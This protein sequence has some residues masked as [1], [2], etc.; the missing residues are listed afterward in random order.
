MEELE[1]LK[2]EIANSA[3]LD[4]CTATNPKIPTPLNVI[5]IIGKIKE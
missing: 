2:E 5:E 3:L 1:K 4:A